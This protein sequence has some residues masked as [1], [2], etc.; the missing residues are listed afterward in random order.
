MR[1]VVVAVGTRQPAWV[2]AAFADYAKRMP[3][4]LRVELKEVKA[5][6]RGS[7]RTAAQAMAAEAVRIDA[8]I[9]RGMRR[10]VLDEH[11]ERVTSAALARRVQAWQRD[12]RDAAL[13]IGG[14]DGLDPALKERADETLRVS[15][16]TL[17]HA[18]VRVVVAEALYRA[19]TI[20]A[21]HPYHRE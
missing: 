12:G 3:A 15:D 21:G 16:L 6:P 20:L 19:S 1:I 5:E 8:A 17:P 9:A 18:L 13:V 2:D 10:V 7:A 4:E 14:A 11:G